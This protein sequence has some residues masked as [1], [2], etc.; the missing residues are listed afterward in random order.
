MDQPDY[1]EDQ[2]GNCRRSWDGQ[3][4]RPHDPARDTPAHRREPMDCADANDCSGNG[5]CRT[6]GNS[7]QGSAE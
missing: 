4:P 2:G 7:R 6:H 3:N 1:P 5:V